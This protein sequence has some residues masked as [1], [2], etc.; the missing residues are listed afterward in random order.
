[1][2]VYEEALIKALRENT[3][4]LHL[5][6]SDLTTLMSKNYKKP[7]TSEINSESNSKSWRN[8]PASDKQKNFMYKNSIPFKESITKGEAS[9]KID[10]FI[11][12]KKK[13]S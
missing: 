12:A 8:E 10:R 13:G 7:I 3:Q 6:R 9:D 4:A 11:D 1:M 2:T 5:L